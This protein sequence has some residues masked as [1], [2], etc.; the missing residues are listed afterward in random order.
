MTGSCN[1]TMILHDVPIAFSR[2]HDS[3][4]SYVKGMLSFQIWHQDVADLC[5]AQHCSYQYK[6]ASFSILS[7]KLAILLGY[8]NASLLCW[9]RQ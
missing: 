6:L 9:G 2:V 3:Q 8:L 4:Q 7:P 1:T 5:F